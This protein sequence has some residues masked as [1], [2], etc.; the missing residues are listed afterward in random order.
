LRVTPA[1]AS[2]TA[3]VVFKPT[4]VTVDGTGSLFISEATR[5]TKVTL[6]GVAS[7]VLDGINGPGAVAFTEDG[8]LLIAQP[9]VHIVLRLSSDG[10]VTTIAGT[11]V[12]G[13]SGDGGPAAAAQLNSP[14]GLA[15]DATGIVWVADS[16][17]N[18]IRSLAPVVA[19][20]ITQNATLVHAA[21]L[22]PGP[23]APDEIVTIFGSKFEPGQTQLL[24]DG[25]AATIFYTGVNQI[26]ALAPAD[27]AVNATTEISIQVR[28]ATVADFP[29]AVVGAAPGIFTT[30]NGG[31][32]Q[33]AANNQ[34]GSIN[35]VSNPADRGSIVVLYATGEG[36]DISAVSVNIGG[37]ASE[38]LY[39]GPAPG[40]PG[41]MQ[42]NARVPGGYAPSGI[43]PVV[44][45]VGGVGTQDGVTIAVR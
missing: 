28:G 15:V 44:I 38:V 6:M 10:T 9:G 24:F 1:G 17:N 7:T 36:R 41:L 42:V 43:L 25:R 23:I 2:N 31:A 37:Y 3:A 5:L 21:S 33:A 34:D 39:A 22:A 40:F 14:T 26:N 32:G 18:R 12:A 19:A 4:A 27:L 30:T 45:T 8:D 16:G 20:A 13:F 11:G 29:C 35:S